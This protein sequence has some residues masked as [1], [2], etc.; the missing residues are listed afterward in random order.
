[1]YVVCVTL[2]QNVKIYFV[3]LL[4]LN[5]GVYSSEPMEHVPLPP[6]LTHSL[7]SSPFFTFIPSPP[8]SVFSVPPFPLHFSFNFPRPFLGT[9]P[10]KS[11]WH[12]GSVVSY[13]NVTLHVPRLIPSVSDHRCCTASRWLFTQMTS[14]RWRLGFNFA[15]RPAVLVCSTGIPDVRRD[16]L[17]REVRRA[18]K[19]CTE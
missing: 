4:L 16:E 10:P 13:L 17:K 14:R 19:R 7:L 11:R 1:M 2:R 9:L 12:L 18:S 15:G 8:L 3:C 5:R 6:S